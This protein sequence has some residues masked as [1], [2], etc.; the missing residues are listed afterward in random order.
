MTVYVCSLSATPDQ[1][2]PPGGG[3]TLLKFPFEENQYDVH[4]MHQPQQP[5]G[6]MAASGDARSGLIWPCVAGWGTLIAH[7][8]WEAGGYDEIRDQFVRDPLG[9][10]SNPMDVTA[11][12]HRAP[13]PGM[14]FFTKTHGIFVKPGVPLGVM[15]RHS[16]KVPRKVTY[17][18]F[19]LVIHP[20]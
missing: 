3:Y 19:K 20:T 13:T 10:T 16:D 14:Q 5:D 15:V 6:I 8:Q 12:D 17:A 2:I 9:F 11:V 1:L 7:F 4:C 18:Q